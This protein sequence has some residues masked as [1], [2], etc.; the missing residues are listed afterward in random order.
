MGDVQ[1]ERERCVAAPSGISRTCSALERV[2]IRWSE[3]ASGLLAACWRRTPPDSPGRTYHH[4]GVPGLTRSP[5]FCR[6]QAAGWHPA[7]SG[8]QGRPRRT[9]LHAHA[10]MPCVHPVST[11]RFFCTS[12]GMGTVLALLVRPAPLPNFGTSQRTPTRASA[13]RWHRHGA[14]TLD[15]HGSSGAVAP[16]TPSERK[17]PRAGQPPRPRLVPLADIGSRA[18]PLG[19][20]SASADARARPVSRPGVRTGSKPARSA[21]LHAACWSG[22]A[23]QCCRTDADPSRAEQRCPRRPYCARRT[24]W[25][26]SRAGDLVSDE[27]PRVCRGHMPALGSARYASWPGGLDCLRSCALGSPISAPRASRCLE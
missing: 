24:G 10:C 14:R 20:V 26:R 19:S 5:G 3:R 11:Q 12:V 27:R 8:A 25:P 13:T 21:L 9:P 6:L 15:A 18:R 23:R 7:G 17:S 1:R 4:S 2:R 16:R 22:A